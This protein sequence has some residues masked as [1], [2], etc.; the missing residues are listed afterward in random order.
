MRGIRK[1]PRSASHAGTATSLVRALALHG[2]ARPCVGRMRSHLASPLR[3]GRGVLIRSVS[4]RLGSVACVREDA[5]PNEVSLSINLRMPV[6]IPSCQTGAPH[7]ARPTEGSA[8]E[9]G[10]DFAPW[11]V[12]EQVAGEPEF[13]TADPGADH[14]D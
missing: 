8:R 11:K 1:T 6:Y 7:A 12:G 3:P 4:R 14:H 9:T 5:S 13:G 10:K 2:V